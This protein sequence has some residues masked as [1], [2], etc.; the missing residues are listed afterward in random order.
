MSVRSLGRVSQHS[1]KMP[2]TFMAQAG[3]E[4]STTSTTWVS[5]RS[6]PISR[7]DHLCL[8]CKREFKG[9]K[10]WKNVNMS[11][12]SLL[13]VYV[14]NGRT[15]P[16]F[17]YTSADMY[18]DIRRDLQQ[19][20]DR[21]RRLLDSRS[22]IRTKI[23]DYIRCADDLNM[24]L[25]LLENDPDMYTSSTEQDIEDTGKTLIFAKLWNIRSTF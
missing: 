21:H 1:L 9:E 6:A 24:H 20:K 14:D 22:K 4:R 7:I 18:D 12:D 16:V 13:P 2:L 3:F 25:R 15:N 11:E 8:M 19:K 5:A 23:L 10:M 17:E